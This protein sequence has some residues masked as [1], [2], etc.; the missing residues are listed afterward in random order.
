[1][2]RVI[3]LAALLAVMTAGCGFGTGNNLGSG[4]TQSA[5]DGTGDVMQ[6]STLQPTEAS[7]PTDAPTLTPLPALTATSTPQMFPL[8]TFAQNTNCRKGPGTGFY[9]VVAYPKG[10]T[11]EV[12]GR[13]EDGSWLWVRMDTNRDYCWAAAGTVIALGDV[14][15]LSVIPYQSLPAA[16]AS[17][18]VTRKGCG[19]TNVI[20]L[21]WS[22][23][24]GAQGYRLY[25]DGALIET[26]PSSVA[27]TIDFVRNARAY[28]YALEAFSEYG[29]SPRVGLSEPG[30]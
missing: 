2:K 17:F 18:D 5:L 19:S 29:V 4:L 27:M 11:A 26:F 24:P 22:R 14:A 15:I 7:T 9:S 20:W 21:A 3:C 10:T 8:V 1:M 12:D 16:P 13:N 28:L 30:C 25:R 6:T 23:V